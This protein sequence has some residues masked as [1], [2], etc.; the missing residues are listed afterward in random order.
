MCRPRRCLHVVRRS[1][2]GRGYARVRARARRRGHVWARRGLDLRVVH[3]ARQLRDGGVGE[4]GGVNDHIMQED[5]PLALL[6]AQ[7]AVA[8]RVV[9]GEQLGEGLDVLGPLHLEVAAQLELAQQLHEHLE[10][11]HVSALLHAR[12]G[13]PRAH[14]ARAPRDERLL[15]GLRVVGLAEVVADD[16]DGHR[17]DQDPRDHGEDGEGAPLRRHGVAVA[18]AHRG[19]RHDGPP[20]GGGDRAVWAE[21]LGQV[22]GRLEWE[23]GRARPRH[24]T[25]PSIRPP[26]GPSIRPH[27]YLDLRLSVCL[28]IC[29][30]VNLSACRRLSRLPINRVYLSLCAHRSAGRPIC[31]HAHMPTLYPTATHPSIHPSICLSIRHLRLCDASLGRRYF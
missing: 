27:A 25:S 22:A 10:L 2:A 30:S 11:D 21:G 13:L 16:G 14:L 6:H 9:L 26:V 23:G 29:R 20:E 3:V 12:L 28:S 5:A 17:D 7:H 4:V 24:G 31:P 18:V 1:D 8:A 19:H 15:E